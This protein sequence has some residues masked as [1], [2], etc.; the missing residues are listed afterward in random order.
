MSQ[1]MKF[2]FSLGLDKIET[3]LVVTSWVGL[4]ICMELL[5]MSPKYTQLTNNIQIKKVL[6]ETIL[7]TL[8]EKT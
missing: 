2:S 7:I 1:L 8:V 6:S 5:K 3:S 4:K